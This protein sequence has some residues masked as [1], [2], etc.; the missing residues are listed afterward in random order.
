MLWEGKG[1]SLGLF[2]ASSGNQKIMETLK[3]LLGEYSSAKIGIEKFDA[4]PVCNNGCGIF[5]GVHELTIALHNE[6]NIILLKVFNQLGN[7]GV[8]GDRF[9]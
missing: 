8:F 1:I 6:V 3:S 2:C 5:L 9:F 4:V 7:G